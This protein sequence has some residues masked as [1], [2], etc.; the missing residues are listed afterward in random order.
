MSGAYNDPL[1][2]ANRAQLLA[3]RPTCIGYPAGRHPRPV[4]ATTADH[5]VPLV[6]GGTHALSNLDP[7]CG[8]CNSRKAK[9]SDIRG[10]WRR[11]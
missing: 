1:Y 11:R 2:Q 3:T 6:Q 4:R 7:M 10:S 8:S 5:R 9:R